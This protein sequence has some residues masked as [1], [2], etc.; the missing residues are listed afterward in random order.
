[1]VLIKIQCFD[2]VGLASERATTC[3]LEYLAVYGRTSMGECAPR[4]VGQSSSKLLKTCYPLRPL[5]MPNFIEISQTSL[6][7]SVK[8]RYLFSPSRRFF[9][10]GQTE[11]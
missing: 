11:T 4:N 9:C 1:M 3:K 7:K 2:T 8:K 5:I 10:H 6:E